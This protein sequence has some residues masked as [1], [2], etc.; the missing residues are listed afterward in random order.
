MRTAKRLAAYVA[1]YG[2]YNMLAGYAER[3][4]D[5][6]LKLSDSFADI[7]KTT[8]LADEEIKKLSRSINEIDTRTTQEELHE[9]AA[10]AGQIGLKST[11]DVL[12]FV[13]A[14]NMITVSLNELGSEGTASLMKLAQ[15]T[16]DVQELGVE[17]SL[18][19]I[20]SAI[21]ELSANSAAT[22]GPIVE[23][24][25]RMGGIAAQS[26][27]TTAE[28][29]AIG[30]TADA[31]GQSME[32]TGTSMNKFIATLLSD[33]DQIAYAL[34]MDAKA[35]N[36]L[37]AGGETMEAMLLIFERMGGISKL[38]PV[39]GDLGSEG[40]RMT[41]MLSAMA[42]NV[43]LLRDQVE[44]SR[45]AFDE[46]VSI[47]NEYNIKNENA[48][49]LLERMKNTIGEMWVNSSFVSGFTWFLK[50]LNDLIKWL[51]EGDTGARLFKTT[52]IAL[53]TA[54]ALASMHLDSFCKALFKAKTYTELFS[55]AWGKLGKMLKANWISLV[56]GALVSLLYYLKSSADYMSKLTRATSEYNSE[57][58]RENNIMASLFIGAKNENLKKQEK[59]KIINEI[60]KRYN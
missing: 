15:L 49:A 56:V 37:I 34:N 25:R 31:I 43:S 12:G 51:A 55:G 7:Q 29:A 42:K 21:N 13:K 14:S 38:A 27:I 20:G 46:A 50:Q 19:A 10:V 32:I 52:M 16:G 23:L 3:L 54:I 47:E 18:L 39:M 6:N 57:L 60:N 24:M 26:S 44:L 9:L 48:I 53:S 58:D 2:G 4:F 11:E 40:A 17:K 22:A 36:E 28:M 5:A 1:V 8:G 33:S 41:Q 59:A 45:E 30:A 35:L